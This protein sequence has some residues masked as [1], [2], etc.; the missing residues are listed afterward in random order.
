MSDG[1][2]DAGAGTRG[3]WNGPVADDRTARQRPPPV[4]TTQPAP[5]SAGVTEWTST[6]SRTG[7]DWSAAHR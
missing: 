6:C 2:P 5:E 7:A 1:S 3:F 4:V